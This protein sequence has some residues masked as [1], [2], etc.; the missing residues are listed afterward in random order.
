M[1]ALPGPGRRKSLPR[2]DNEQTH[3]EGPLRRGRRRQHRAGRG[4]ARVRQRRGESELVALV[5]GDPVKREALPERYA[6][7]EALGDYRE[8]EDVLRRARVDAV[9]VAT[10]NTHHREFTERAAKLGVHVLCE[11]PMAPTVADCEAMIG[12]CR[13]HR[14][15][16]MIAYR[17]HFEAANLQAIEALE[18]GKI[19]DPRMFSSLFTQQ[20]RPGDI[21]TRAELAG[22]ALLDLGVYPINAVR[23]LFREEPIEVLAAVSSSGDAR[24]DGVDETTSAILRF[25]SGRVAQLTVS[26]GGSSMGYYRVVGTEGDLYADPI[27]DYEQ[28]LKFVLTT[29]GKSRE[30]KF[31]ARDQFAP[32]LVEFSRCVLEDREPEPSGEEGLADIRV[33]EAILQS[34]RSGRA[35]QLPPWSR[36][37]RP[38]AG[39]EQ[40]KPPVDPPEPIRAPSPT[41]R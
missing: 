2:H 29:E 39:Q 23:Y 12:V 15:K 8:F 33:V 13:E 16:L 5:S 6:S 21:R 34:A 37:Q 41:I 9:F 22:G 20:V 7:I 31:P 3:P 27:Y 30:H 36:A 17:L 4:P 19:G 28:G 38:D 10:P 25:A 35:V 14:V 40:R 32:E 18:G 26:L 24:F 1:Y 11:K